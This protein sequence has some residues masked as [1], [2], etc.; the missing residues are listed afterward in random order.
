MDYKIL[1]CYKFGFKTGENAENLQL[2][3]LLM[4]FN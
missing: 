3:P 4:N 1:N 2:R